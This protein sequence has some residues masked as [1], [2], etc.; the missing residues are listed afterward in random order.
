MPAP[1][2]HFVSSHYQDKIQ[3]V[4]NLNQTGMSIGLYLLLVTVIIDYPLLSA[5]GYEFKYY[6]NK[7]K[8]VT[9]IHERTIIRPC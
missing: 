8:G 5:N 9:H 4:N 3:D 6:L 1:S 7:G 2:R